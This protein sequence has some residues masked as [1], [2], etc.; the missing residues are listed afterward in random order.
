[1]GP[2]PARTHFPEGGARRRAEIIA[3]AF[4]TFA[5]D[6]YRGASM[7]Q[8][9]AACGVSR[10][11]L[12]TTSPP[13]DP[14]PA[15]VLEE[16]DRVNG[17]LFFHDTDPKRDGIHYL[18][19]LLQVLKHNEGERE[20]VRLF[21]TLSTEAADPDHPAHAYI[22]NRFRWLEDD[23]DQALRE[24]QARGLVR[25]GA[26]LDGFARD[27]IALIDGLQIRWLIDP[28]GVDMAGRAHKRLMDIL[29]T[30]PMA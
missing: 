28:A 23:I 25:P 24:A 14:P 29:T 16:R 9:A 4:T 27:L 13:R 1:M 10:A 26:D 21:A 19:Q 17:E 11:G 6:G 12:L 2:D 8:I 30:D 3:A 15:A 18:R 22:A 20:L 7:V 5:A